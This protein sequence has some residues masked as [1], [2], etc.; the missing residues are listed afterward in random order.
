MT[1]KQHG[2]R[3]AGPPT[4]VVRLPVMLADMAH[5]LA[6]AK[7]PGEVAAFLDVES[8]SALRVPMMAWS[9]TCGFPSPAE[10]YVDR[11]LDFN[12]LLIEHPAATFAIR[13]EGESMTGAGIFPGDIAVVDR[14]K[15]PVN[16]SIVLALLDGSFTVKR[17]RRFFCRPKT[18]RLRTWR[19]R[20][21]KASRCGALSRAASACCDHGRPD[22]PRRLQQFLCVVR[23]RVSAGIARTARCRALEQ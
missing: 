5:D 12:E 10:D 14:A 8:R 9:A 13:I 1:N 11:P 20:T 7:N 3:R 22:R 18:Q 23:A 19:C 21:G 6:A 15:E 4:K 17:Y 2:G 16:G